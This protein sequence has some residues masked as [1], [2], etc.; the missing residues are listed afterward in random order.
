MSFQPDF[1]LEYAHFLHDYY[2]AKGINN[3]K[4]YT[5][6]HVA[7]NGRLSRPYIDPKINLADK[8]ESFKHKDWILPFNETIWGL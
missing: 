4:V 8:N 7:L 3:P 5:E 1:I 2:E 6:C